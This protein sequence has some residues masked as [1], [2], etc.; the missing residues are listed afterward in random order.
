MIFEAEH[1]PR[2][3]YELLCQRLLLHTWMVRRLT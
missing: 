2:A 3:D 1:P